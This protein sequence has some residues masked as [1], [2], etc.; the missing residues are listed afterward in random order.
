MPS[1]LAGMRC[2]DTK[3]TMMCKRYAGGDE[4]VSPGKKHRQSQ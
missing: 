1:D 2:H 3:S 4:V